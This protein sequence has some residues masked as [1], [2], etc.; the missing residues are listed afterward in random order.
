MIK[1]VFHILMFMFVALGETKAT[2]LLLH[3]RDKESKQSIMGATLEIRMPGDKT[4]K[5]MQAVNGQIEIAEPVY[6]IGIECRHTGYETVQLS[7][8]ENMIS[9]QANQASYTLEMSVSI[10]AIPDMVI[11]AQ[12]VPVLARQSIYKVNTLSGTDIQQRGA[13]SLNEALNFELN[14]FISNDNLLGS[15]VNLG[16]IGGQNVK[17]L[18]NGIPVMGRENGNIDMGQLNLNNIKRIEM[19]QGPMSVLYGSNALGGVINLITNTP[20]TKLSGNVRSYMESIGRYNINAQAGG[21]YKNHE[22]QVSMARNFF[23]GWTPKDSIDRFQLW[24]PKTQYTGDINYGYQYKKLKLNYYGS[25][26]SEKVT[27]K[28]MPIINPYEG[29]AFDEYYRTKRMIQSLSGVI[30]MSETDQITLQHSYQYYQRIK[31]RFRKDLVTLNELETRNVGDQD[32]SRF[33]HVNLRGIYHT[34]RFRK[35]D[36]QA[37]YE[38]SYEK[39]VSYKLQ[40][41]EQQISETGL[42][43]SALYTHQRLQLQPSARITYNNRYGTAL[44]PAFHAKIDLNSRAQ[45]RASY[46]RGFRAPTLKEMHLQFIDQNHTI[47]GNPELQP[48]TGD[49]IQTG[50]DYTIQKGKASYTLGVTA[51]YNNIRNLIA[52]AVFNNHGILRKYD[53]IETYRNRMV[54]VRGRMEKPGLILQAG[55]GLMMVEQTVVTP[56]M[57]ISEM[58]CNAQYVIKA[59]QTTV[60]ANYKFNSRQPVV[61]IDQQFLYTT[62][63]HIA[64]LSVQRHFFK[65]A[66]LAQAGV[67]NLLNIQNANLTGNINTQSSGHSTNSMMQMFPTRSIF[68]DL[69][70][71]F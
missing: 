11:T 52:L 57:L 4:G 26:L 45:F 66:L 69:T 64:N 60:A 23:T 59:I 43:A 53:N 28:G 13:V 36:M 67:K 34:N 9:V 24:K 42:F 37:G 70:Y 10:K 33:H 62:P 41:D 21:K 47:I 38:Y 63:L 30:R 18:V 16:G 71:S 55:A 1:I 3:I 46:A 51:F 6:P 54:N 2:N 8:T 12:A 44:T 7:V 32:T 39:G 20:K 5:V 19:I 40:D 35:F 27:N 22:L 29:Y 68:I 50:I 61:T 48:E 65:K 15:S 25:L 17:I 49:H 31:N 58:S 56:K 14:S